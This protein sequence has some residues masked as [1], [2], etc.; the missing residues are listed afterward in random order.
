[1]IDKSQ[2]TT[3]LEHVHDYYEP[4]YVVETNVNSFLWKM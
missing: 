1:M 4:L 3:K 2:I